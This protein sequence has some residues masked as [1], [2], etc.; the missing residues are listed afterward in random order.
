MGAARHKPAML[1]FYRGMG[2]AVSDANGVK[3]I[4]NAVT[5]SVRV[6]LLLYGCSREE[7]RRAQ[8]VWQFR[9]L[10][11]VSSSTRKDDVQA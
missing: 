10:G 4:F 6:L 7:C 11:A 1:G 5:G 9:L 8:A 2:R 3:I